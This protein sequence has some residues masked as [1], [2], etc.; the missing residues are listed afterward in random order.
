MPAT[1]KI[2]FGAVTYGYTLMN[3]REIVEDENKEVS[4]KW[5]MD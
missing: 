5:R 4:W 2:V 3:I 1:E